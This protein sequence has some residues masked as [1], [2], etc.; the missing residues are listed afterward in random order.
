MDE[1]CSEISTWYIC[2]HG[3]SYFGFPNWDIGEGTTANTSTGIECHTLYAA[4]CGFVGSS[5][6]VNKCRSVKG[7]RE[8]FRGKKKLSEVI[9][10]INIE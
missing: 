1:M 8:I 6:S 7:Y 5:G 2:S 10:D 9:Y 3:T 4:L